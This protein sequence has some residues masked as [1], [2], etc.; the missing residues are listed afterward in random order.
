VQQWVTWSL[1]PPFGGEFVITRN[2]YD[3][4]LAQFKFLTF[5]YFNNTKRHHQMC[6][7]LLHL[8]NA[9]HSRSLAM[10]S[11]YIKRIRLPLCIYRVVQ[12]FFQIL[13]G[14]RNYFT[15]KIRKNG[16]NTRPLLL[17]SHHILSVSLH[18]LVICQVS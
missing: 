11:F 15:A 18:Y 13:T 5:T 12:N 9:G 16:N 10:S 4:P 3:Q 1:P 17:K 2:C 8:V 7:I 14:L 6:T